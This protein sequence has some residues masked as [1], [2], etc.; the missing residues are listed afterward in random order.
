MAQAKTF[1]ICTQL[2]IIVV[3]MK[4]M[5]AARSAMMLTDVGPPPSYPPPPSGPYPPPPKIGFPSLELFEM[6]QAEEQVECPEAH[7]SQFRRRWACRMLKR[8]R[9]PKLNVAQLRLSG[10]FKTR[11][12]STLAN[13]RKER[14]EP[15]HEGALCFQGEASVSDSGCIANE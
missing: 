11:N 2:F 10:K 12:R 3:P 4:T 5:S 9:G 6:Q 13:G 14:C 15:A 1:W 7:A 8:R